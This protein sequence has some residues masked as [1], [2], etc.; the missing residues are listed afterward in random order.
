MP[1]ENLQK[2]SNYPEYRNNTG[3]MITNQTFRIYIQL[4]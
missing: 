3:I 2:W 1:I 4:S